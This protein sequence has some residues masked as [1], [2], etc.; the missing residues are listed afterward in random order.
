MIDKSNMREIYDTLIDSYS[1]QQHDTVFSFSDKGTQH[2]YIQLYELYF[3]LKKSSVSLLEIGMMTGGS[4]H[5]WQK[6][7]DKY[8][9]VGLD[10]LSTWSSPCAFQAEIE[11]DPNIH[12]VFGVDST[13]DPVPDVVASQSFDFIIDDGDHR[14]GAQLETF[15]RYWPYVKSGGGVYFIED[16]VSQQAIAQLEN[17]ISK[18]VLD[19]GLVTHFTGVVDRRADDRVLIIRKH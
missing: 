4:M 12:L 17:T 7:F 1:D 9:L 19:T 13:K 10:I 15:K 3:A 16:V 11:Q 8:N 18:I 6:Y 14:I 2:T 5:L